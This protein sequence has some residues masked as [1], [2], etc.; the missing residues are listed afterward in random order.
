MA[1][2][3]TAIKTV[4][5]TT[6]LPVPAP[7]PAAD[8]PVLDPYTVLKYPLST[9]KSVRQIEFENK[10]S[11]AVDGRA[12]KPE[13]KKAV[14]ELYKVKVLKVNI[15]NSFSG[16]KKAIVKLSPQHSAADLSADLG[17]I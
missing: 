10:I 5:K 8:L 3:R 6:A 14:E 17:M 12:T 9:E 16:I 2:K 7:V 4:K 15:H 1:L 11:F 13:V